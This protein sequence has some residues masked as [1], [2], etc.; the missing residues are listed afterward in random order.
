MNTFFT[1][2]INKGFA[3]ISIIFLLTIIFFGIGSFLTYVLLNTSHEAELS[4]KKVRSYWAMAGELDY[5]LSR[6]RQSN[7]TYTKSC[8]N[9]LEFED[10]NFFREVDTWIYSVQESYEISH[11]CAY[12]EVRMSTNKDRLLSELKV[13]INIAKGEATVTSWQWR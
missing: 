12:S 4:L 1:K 6:C 2:N 9:F 10:Y 13:G 8:N 11:L 5:A 7:R 3:S